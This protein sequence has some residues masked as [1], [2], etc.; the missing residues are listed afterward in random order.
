MCWWNIRV[1]NIFSPFNADAIREMNK[2]GDE[3]H[4]S[5]QSHGDRHLDAQASIIH[6]SQFY[7]NFSKIFVGVTK[8]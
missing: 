4:D 3:Q 6:N 5:Q 2:Y 1:Q 7:S 8:P